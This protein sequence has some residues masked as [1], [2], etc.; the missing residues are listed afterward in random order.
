MLKQSDYYINAYWGSRIH[1]LSRLSDAVFECLSCL[2]SSHPLFI[3]WMR[4]SRAHAEA[5]Q[6]LV[7]INQLS[8]EQLMHDYVDGKK[9]VYHTTNGIPITIELWNEDVVQNAAVFSLSVILRDT[10]RQ[11]DINTC[12]V[13]FSSIA[14]LSSIERLIDILTCFVSAWDPDVAVVNSYSYL[15]S[16]HHQGMFPP[17]GW[18]T[19]VH[20]ASDLLPPLP[21]A[22]RVTKLSP[23]GSLIVAS[24]HQLL[25]ENQEHMSL[26][27]EIGVTLSRS[28]FLELR[29]H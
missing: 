16:N 6:Q 23:G 18:I 2:A 29:T 22:Y 8:I 5:V 21:T 24:R 15:G 14:N 17:V 3:K 9:S 11:A 1:R 4:P 27:D 12:G 13:R 28:G 26:L 10:L 25:G 7:P 20:A 19:Y